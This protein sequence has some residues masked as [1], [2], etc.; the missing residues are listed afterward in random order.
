MKA[1]EIIT[2]TRKA[3]FRFMKEVLPTWPDYVIRD[4]IYPHLAKGDH[5]RKADPNDPYDEPIQFDAQ[6]ILDYIEIE[7]L[8]PNQKWDYVPNFEF[9]IDKMSPDVQEVLTKRI[10]GQGSNVP[11]DK[12]R[13]QTQSELLQKRG[14]S[15]EPVIMILGNDGYFLVE[16]WH[17]T[18]QNFIKYPNG[19]TG[20]AYITRG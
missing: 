15:K 10:G 14:I 5:P 8:S 2:E 18:I 12:E 16:G 11:R 9:T 4:W 19:Y 7:H 1:A 6:T 17:R 3:M 13:N 20:P